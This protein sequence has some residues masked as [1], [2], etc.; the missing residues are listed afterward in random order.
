M[1]VDNFTLVEDSIFAIWWYN[2]NYGWLAWDCSRY[3]MSLLLIRRTTS[4]E[5]Q[6]LYDEL[7]GG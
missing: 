5:K 7:L 1:I 3:H 6:Q 2:S 4:R